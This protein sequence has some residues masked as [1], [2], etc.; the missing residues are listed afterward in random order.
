M[1]R[2]TKYWKT[3]SKIGA[4][5]FIFTALLIGVILQPKSASAQISGVIPGTQPNSI[6]LKLSA[7]SPTNKFYYVI[8]NAPLGSIPSLGIP[9]PALGTI[10]LA[11]MGTN[12]V[13]LPAQLYTIGSNIQY[14]VLYNMNTY[15]VLDVYEVNENKAIVAFKEFSPISNYAAA[16]VANVS[17]PSSGSSAGSTQ[18]SLTPVYGSGAFKIQISTKVISSLPANA[19]TAKGTAY[20]SGINNVTGVDPVKNRYLDIYEVDTSGKTLAFKEVIL[21]P[22]M[23]AAPE[24]KN[25]SANAGTTPSSTVLKLS[26]AKSGDQFYYTTSALPSSSPASL[27]SMTWGKSVPNIGSDGS[28]LALSANQYT[29]GM[30]L[31]LNLA[32]PY[33][34][35]YEVDD[36][37]SIV[38]FKEFSI[39]S[40]NQAV[41]TITTTPV[42]W[43]GTSAGS[44]KLINLTPS[45]PSALDTFKV[46]VSSKPL[47]TLPAVGS[48]PKGTP[49]SITSP[50]DIAGVDPVKNKYIDVYEVNSTGNTV[51]F[52]EIVLDQSNLTAPNLKSA[53]AL[54]G[55]APL[56]TKFKITPTKA[57]DSFVYVYPAL[58]GSRPG[59]G[60]ATPALGITT[61]LGTNYICANYSS[62]NTIDLSSMPTPLL[63]LTALTS[64]SFDVYEVD[65]S[66]NNAIVAYSKVTVNANAITVPSINISSVANAF[67][68]TLAGST[69]LLALPPVS[70]A[71]GSYKVLVA[72][73]AATSLPALGDSSKGVPYVLGTNILNVDTVKNKYLDIYEVDANGKTVKFIELTLLNGN[74]TAPDLK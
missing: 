68:G 1:I 62:G 67:P 35:V 12:P 50:V 66:S 48:V 20:N 54:T 5:T 27:T 36:T 17:I 11:L 69:S 44:T 24:I 61:I 40:S 15:Y 4:T 37:M 46:L 42:A 73:K 23:V 33:L 3:L 71:G 60:T 43:Y 41:P 2:F 59:L 29:T 10:T 22:T 25:A 52:N 55:S 58:A 53:S 49:Y 16:P 18:L 7:Y 45:D 64:L 9:A 19:S 65:P 74:M 51:A 31:Y 38:A 8:R 6:A 72:N 32:N 57:G 13:A 39:I 30:E 28:T 47:S 34:D 26:T 70:T 21:K 14:N 56:N 63:A